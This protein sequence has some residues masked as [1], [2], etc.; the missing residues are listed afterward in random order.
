MVRKRN[1]F[2]S[3]KKYERDVRERE[4]ERER[5]GKLHIHNNGK[6][7][8]RTKKLHAWCVQET[9]KNPKPKMRERR[10]RKWSLKIKSLKKRKKPRHYYYYYYYYW[11]IF[12]D[13]DIPEV[14][15]SHTPYFQF[16]YQK[17]FADEALRFSSR[18]SMPNNF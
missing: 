6:K 4:R 9:K 8:R 16:Q 11:W 13:D 17:K 5:E 12:K 7:R 15:R 3:L 10:S 2:F 14:G 18:S 1:K